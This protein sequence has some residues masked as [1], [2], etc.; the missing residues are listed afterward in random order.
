MKKNKLNETFLVRGIIDRVD[1]IR[2]SDGSVVLK[3]VDY[4]TSS[5]PN[6]KYTTETNVRIAHEQFWQLKVYALLMR[7]Q[8]Y[9]GDSINNNTGYYSV[10]L[11]MLRLMFLGGESPRF[12]DMDLGASQ[13][14]RDSVLQDV[15]ADLSNIW[16]K[17]HELVSTQNPKAFQHV[18]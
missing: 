13:K 9:S 16:T 17:I 4:K 10:P 5:P 3:I 2:T 7:E 1:I 11:R 12:L 18:T 8:N 14:E 6:F 15:H